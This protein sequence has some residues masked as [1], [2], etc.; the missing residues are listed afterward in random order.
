MRV[1]LFE[2]PRAAVLRVAQLAHHVDEAQDLDT[3]GLLGE[4]DQ[5]DLD[6]GALRRRPDRHGQPEVVRAE[7]VDHA[8]VRLCPLDERLRVLAVRGVTG[9]GQVEVR[10]LERGRLERD[11]VDPGEVQVWR[12]RV[13]IRVAQQHDVGRTE[14]VP[15]L[16][17]QQA[18]QPG[19][20][21]DE[22]D[23]G[24]GR[25]HCSAGWPSSAGSLPGAVL[26]GQLEVATLTDG[27]VRIH[28]ASLLGVPLAEPGGHG[29]LGVGERLLVAREQ[30]GVLLVLLL[31]LR[32]ELRLGRLERRRVLDLEDLDDVEPEVGLDR[33]E[34]LADLGVRDRVGELR[35]VAAG[36]SDAEVAAVLG[37]TVES[38]R[39]RPRRRSPRRPRCGRGRP[40]PRPRCRRGCGGSRS[41]ARRSRRRARA[42]PRR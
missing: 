17:G 1:V 19:V 39:P 2:V 16:E 34:Q 29:H 26:R 6:P 3:G 25:G 5:L 37:R 8:A 41:V 18:R 12:R 21:L 35:H 31:E 23:G 7:Q 28:D 30:L 40:A 42:R 11:E 38:T 32:A 10:T 22:D 20:G 24:R 14:R 33:A 15:G 9:A 27:C 4:E 13:G 36:R